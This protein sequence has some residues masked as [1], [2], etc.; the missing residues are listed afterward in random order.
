[1][2]FTNNWECIQ[3]ITWPQWFYWFWILNFI[4]LNES[5]SVNI[6]PVQ[7]QIGSSYL[8]F[9]EYEADQSFIVS[10]KVSLLFRSMINKR[11]QNVNWLFNLGG[12][13]LVDIWFVYM[14][15][16]RRKTLFS[17]ICLKKEILHFFQQSI[18]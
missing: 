17:E 5:L 7:G 12:Y 4:V 16:I 2:D 3:I 9:V 10:K 18:W 8:A 1:M 11:I 15:N 14:G 13:S 6:D